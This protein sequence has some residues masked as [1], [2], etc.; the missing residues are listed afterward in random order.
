MIYTMMQVCKKA[1][2]TYQAFK[3]YCNKDLIPM[4]N[5]IKT[6]AVFLI[7]ETSVT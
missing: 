1:N 2:L 3:F 4:S 5:G 6:T 7:S